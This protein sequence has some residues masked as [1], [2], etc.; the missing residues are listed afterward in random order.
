MG[1]SQEASQLL[2]NL[3]NQELFGNMVQVSL[4]KLGEKDVNPSEFDL[5]DGSRSTKMYSSDETCWPEQSVAPT[6]V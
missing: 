1:S 2:K 4:T 3:F 5:E 6:K